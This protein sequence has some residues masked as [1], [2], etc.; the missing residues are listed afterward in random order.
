MNAM[1]NSLIP[2]SEPLPTALRDVVQLWAE[3]V[4]PLDARRR[5]DVL[6][7]RLRALLGKGQRGTAAGFFVFARKAPDVV[8]PLDVQ[9]WREYLEQ[10]GLKPNTVYSLVSKLSSFYTWLQRDPA[11]RARIPRNPVDMARPQAPKAYQSERAEALTDAEA[12]ALLAVV[13]ADAARGSLH[14][15]RDYVLLRLYFATGKR[16]EEIVQLRWGDIK[17][18]RRGL[19]LRTREKGGVYANTEVR[20]TGL[21]GALLNYLR[22]SGRWDEARDKPLLDPRDPLWLRHDRAAKGQ[23]PITSH[24]FV[25]N[26]KDYA[27]RAGLGDI[28]L[29]QTRYTTG[30]LVAELSGDIKQVQTVLGHQHEG[31]TRRY[32]QRVAVKRDRF[33]PRIARRLRL[34]EDE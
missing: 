1:S 13:L 7:D 4:T 28:H 34:A 24:G 8:S 15:Q 31:T 23:Q 32:V 6:R 17:F 5:A 30:R 2:L 25:Y 16:R 29:H 33:S 12:R 26:L 21:R 3:Q 11:M 14:A 27:R 18:T 20:D 9:A 22:A 19:L 10:M